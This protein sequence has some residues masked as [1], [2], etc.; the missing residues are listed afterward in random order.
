[1]IDNGSVYPGIKRFDSAGKAL[2]VIGAVA[3]VGLIVSGHDLHALKSLWQGYLF[4]WILVMQFAVGCLGMLLLQN[5]VTA[6]WGHPIVRI[7][8]AGAR[9]LPFLFV[10]FLPVMFVG[11]RYIYPWAD[12]HI[13]A[14]DAVVKHKAIL[15]NPFWFGARTFLYFA[16][17]FL[18]SE[19]L[20]RLSSQQDRTGDK[21]LAQTRTD[22]SGF[23]FVVYVMTTTFAFTDWVMSV[24]PHWYSTIYGAWFLVSC[25]LA[26]L[27]FAVIIATRG[28]LS[29]QGPYTEAILTD[30]V[31]R[32]WGNL[33][34][35]MCMVWA[36]F[37]LSQWLIQWSGNLPEEIIF[38]I[39]RFRGAWLYVG[40]FIMIFQFFGPF[41]C[42]LSGKTKR[43]PP[44]LLSMAMWL[45]FMR[46]VDIGWNVLPVFH[47][48]TILLL[49]FTAASLATIAG[50]WFTAFAWFANKNT[51][52]PAFLTQASGEALEH[53]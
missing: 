5:M 19:F 48:D 22:Y 44:L 33:F 46:F 17:W 43:R 24:E 28:L 47:N 9:A 49:A 4:A 6:T 1:M 11:Y 34:L 16:I 36:Y 51:L 25:G 8:E 37:S 2:T 12:P 18:Y 50:V 38:Y 26:G 35:T 40:A 13:L 41:L 42:L 31:K 27:S 23:G 3:L 45:V 32:D 14:T 52:L 20:T 7:F 30:T 39:H 29:R 10:L 53:A 21:S 15:E